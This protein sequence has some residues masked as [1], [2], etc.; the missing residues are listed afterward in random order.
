MKRPPNYTERAYLLL[1]ITTLAAM[2][3]LIAVKS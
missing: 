2:L 1:F 3:W